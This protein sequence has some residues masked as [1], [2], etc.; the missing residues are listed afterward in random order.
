MFNQKKYEDCLKK[1]KN[2]DI[3]DNLIYELTEFKHQKLL[4]KYGGKFN[5]RRIWGIVFSHRTICMDYIKF[6]QGEKNV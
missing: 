1:F 3:T 5:N 2:E 4:F 6:L